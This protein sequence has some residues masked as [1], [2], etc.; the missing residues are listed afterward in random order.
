MNKLVAVASATAL[1]ML[2]SMLAVVGCSSDSAPMETDLDAGTDADSGKKKDVETPDGDP[3]PDPKCV[4]SDPIDATQFAYKPAARIPAACTEDEAK[5]LFD[6]FAAKT[7]AGETVSMSQWAAEVSTKCSECVFSDGTGERWTPIIVKDDKLH[8]LNRGG[9][10]EIETKS[11]E[12]GEAYQQ[13]TDC[14]YA[15]CSKCTSDETFLECL[16]DAPSIFGGPCKEAFEKV[17]AACDGAVEA[18]EQACRGEDW[19]FEG[20]IR[21]Q[22]VGED[23]P[24]GG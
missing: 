22:C 5:A 7:N 4:T 19:Q 15:A 21:A 16:Q 9:C 17:T 12:C 13:V 8:S 6:Y 10:V 20:P 14:R 24:D 11:S 1:S 23:E 18:A 2:V 3:P